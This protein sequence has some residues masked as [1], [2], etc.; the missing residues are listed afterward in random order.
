MYNDVYIHVHKYN[1]YYIHMTLAAL[2]ELTV[3]EKTLELS[4]KG[5]E[6]K[7]CTLPT[8]V[9]KRPS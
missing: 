9:P 4:W 8:E 6:P 3:L 1:N 5:L 7:A 2:R